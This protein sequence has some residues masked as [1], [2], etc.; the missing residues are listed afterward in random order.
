MGLQE[1]DLPALY[2]TADANSVEAQQSFIKWTRGG[3]IA[4][5]VAAGAGAFTLTIG[6]ADAAG[7]VALIAFIVAIRLCLHL[8]NER[9]ERVWYDGRAAAESAKTLAWRYAVGGQPFETGLNTQEV[10]KRF[11]E[12]LREIPSGLDARGL[13]RSPGTPND[14]I[15]R[16]MQD[17]RVKSLDERKSAYRK[18]RIRDQLSWYSRRADWN[19][20]RAKQW[21][22]A[23]ITIECLGAAAA[24]F[25]AAGL[26]PIDL[27][28]FAG[29]LVAAGVSWLQTKQHSNLAKAYSVAANERSMID[30]LLPSY[31]TEEAWAK[32]VDEAEA[33]IS[34]EHTLSDKASYVKQLQEEGKRVAMVGDGVNDAPALAQADIGIAIGAGTDVAIETAKVVLMKS[35]PLDVTRAIVLSK[36]TVRKMKQNLL[37][38]SVYNVLAIP[39]AA[40]VLYPSYAIMLRPEWSAL[41]MSLSSIIVAVNAVLL[42]GVEKD[43]AEPDTGKGLV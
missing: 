19:D 35:D 4:V 37:W 30:A 8:L 39:I 31:T 28:G 16:G 9:P 18:G 6:P 24:I 25:K 22:R 20:R 2:K 36:A 33:A 14:E 27:L 34:R 32:F 3:L 7:I 41:L 17:L 38:A 5:V 21:N 13:V 10:N 43:L 11:V 1:G 26:L 42:K 12:Q 15:T 40:G 23:L 29:A